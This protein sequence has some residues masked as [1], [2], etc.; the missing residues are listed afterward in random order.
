MNLDTQF[1]L[2]R[3]PLYINYLHEH[4]NWYKLLNRDPKNFGL[5]EEQVKTDY[6][7]RPTDRLN[8]ALEYMDMI[9]AIMSTLK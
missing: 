2:K 4:S 3:E 6:K 5:F 9:E 7:L 1:K 8:K